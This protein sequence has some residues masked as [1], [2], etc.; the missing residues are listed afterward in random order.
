M[1]FKKGNLNGPMVV[2][3]TSPSGLQA[4][5]PIVQTKTVSQSGLDQP[6]SGTTPPV[7]MENHLSAKKLSQVR[8]GNNNNNNNNNNDKNKFQASSEK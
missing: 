2:P 4:V 1:R 8:N 6:H 3:T 5:L 7:V